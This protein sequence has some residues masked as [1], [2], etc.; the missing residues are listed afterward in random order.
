M[1]KASLQNKIIVVTQP[2]P[3]NKTFQNNLSQEGAT[4]YTFPTIKIMENLL[5]EK[6]DKIL[7]NIASYDWIIFTSVKGV[8][9]FMH[10]LEKLK[11]N[12]NILRNKKIGAVGPR[13]AYKIQSYGLS[14]QFIPKTYT[15]EYLAKEIKDIT[16]K[17]IL[18]ARSDIAPK[19]LIRDLERKKGIVT[20]I[21]TYKTRYITTS[22]LI[23]EKMIKTD[24]IDFITFTSPSTV[25]GFFKRIIN[26]EVRNKLYTIPVLC[27]GPVTKKATEKFG[28]KYIFTPDTY[29]TD[30]MIKKLQD[31]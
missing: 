21:P 30:G 3:E 1:S 7:E 20:D 25:Q 13:T 11:I 23:F 18:L 24:K 26:E 31:L 29:T 22:D 2:E 27:I 19:K 14:V 12:K 15:S 6:I 5:D 28:F 9:S 17:K 8:T 10:I 4:V 16:H